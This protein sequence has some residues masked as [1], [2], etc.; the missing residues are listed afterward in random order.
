MTTARIPSPTE[1]LATHPAATPDQ[2]AT[3]L[4]LSVRREEQAPDVQGVI[5]RAEYRPGG[6]IVLYGTTDPCTETYLIAHELYHALAEQAGLSRWQVRESEADA[7]A[8]AL[9][10]ALS[11]HG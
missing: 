7:W 5:V 11:R 1:L 6:D 8:E 3:A 9:L 10:A 2:L 4:G